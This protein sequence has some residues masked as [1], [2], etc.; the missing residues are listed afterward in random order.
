MD[1][2]RNMTGRAT[3]RGAI[4][5]S[6]AGAALIPL[7]SYRAANISQ[8]LGGIIDARGKSKESGQG[9]IIDAH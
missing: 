8:K 7:G 2:L 6:L 9:S 3:S 1:N 5:Q 4:A